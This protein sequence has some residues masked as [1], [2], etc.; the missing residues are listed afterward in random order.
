MIS[1]HEIARIFNEIADLMEVREDSPFKVRA[2]RK[3]AE[4]IEG[5]TESLESIAAR[6]E[7]EKIPSIG[8]A[9]AEKITDICRT[10]TTPLYDELRAEVPSGLVDIL[11]IPGI[12]PS[13]VRALHE[14]LGISSIDELEA[15]AREH[16]V[17]N[18][19]GM[20]A[21]TEENILH[22][23]EA[24]RRRSQRWPLGKALPYSEQLA[25]SLSQQSGGVRV[26]VLG[27]IRRRVD[28]IGDIDLGAETTEPERVMAAFVRLPHVKEVLVSGPAST[29]VRT[30]AGIQVD[31][32]AA[33]PED[34]GFL[35]HH[36]T[37]SRAH[38][39][40]LREIAERRGARI[41]E[42]GIFAAGTDQEL[43]AGEDEAEVYRFLGL[44]DIPPE[45]RE[46]RGEIEAAQ[47]GT[48]PNL[49]TESDIR[50]N[51]HSHSTWSDGTVS[52]EAM[53]NAARARGHRYIAI[54]DHSK[55]LGITNGLDEERLRAQIAEIDGLNAA[56]A[57]SFRIL[58]GSEVDILTDG[59][60]DLDPALLEVLDFV[61]ASV[62]SRFNL[63]EAAMTARIIRA[64]ESGVVDLIAHPTGRLLG[65][66]DPYAVNLEKLFDAAATTQTAL[67][68]NA[69]P[70]RL[71][72]NDVNARRARDRGVMISIN[73]DAH[74]PDH[75]G[76][77][78]FGIATAR[79]GWI[80][81][82]DV[83]NTWELDAL[84]AW[85]R[86]RRKT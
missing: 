78:F 64:M 61:I 77:F 21:K 14:A 65:A 36:F 70:D 51:L 2:Y 33:R 37:G 79:R 60:L 83:I 85:L 47:A 69:F 8:K 22:A 57:D 19:A 71:D 86:E 38:N 28:T 41:S 5:L 72:L 67:E 1:N 12:G 30:H 32:R 29:R 46:D 59:T 44:P 74:H 17:R 16:R 4:T 80:T 54:T 3:A 56:A 48:L 66:R 6:G 68:I 31:L 84:L 50:G 45:L 52:I 15:A 23:I 20:G 10:G 75:L 40:R 35:V 7:L 55:A 26:E 25:A 58:K 62:H 76:L 81:A 63:D 24:H 43:T 39:I 27:S 18:V 42:Y 9:I 73:T 53:A 13:K 34:F 82:R 11:A 49:I